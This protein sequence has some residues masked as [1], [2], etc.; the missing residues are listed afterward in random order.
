MR[1]Y[2]LAAVAAVAIAT[3]VP[4]TAQAA[5]ANNLWK[6][7]DRVLTKA[8]YVD[9]T[10][11]ITPNMPVWKGFGPAQFSPA[12]DPVT[13]QPYTYAEAG[14]EATAYLICTA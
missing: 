1:G 6:V 10:H 2:R 9:L 14:F 12:V 7:Y 4:G 8:H 13:G 5:G 11:T 3:A